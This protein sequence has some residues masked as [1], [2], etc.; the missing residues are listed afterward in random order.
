MLEQL[1]KKATGGLDNVINELINAAQDKLKEKIAEV[2][3]INKLEKLK[4]NIARV[5]KVK[6]ILNPD[7]IM[8]LKDIFIE[9]AIS[10]NDAGIFQSVEDFISNH[11]LIEGRA[12]TRK[13]IVS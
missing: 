11:I 13:V 9:S 2:F 12:R 5:G 8:E 7:S 3:S 6:T 10:L 1:I 4:T